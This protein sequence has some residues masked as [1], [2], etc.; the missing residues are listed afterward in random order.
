MVKIKVHDLLVWFT[1]VWLVSSLSACGNI[2]PTLLTPTESRP[3]QP[4]ANNSPFP[5]ENENGTEI[6]PPSVNVPIGIAPAIDGTLSP[7]EWDDAIVETFADGSHLLLLQAADFIYLGIR[8]HDPGLIAGNIFLSRG[9]E[10]AIMHSSAA[11]GTA[12]YQQ[13][14]DGW[15][16]VQDFTWRCRN[17]SDSESARVERAEFLQDE[18]WLAAN[19]LM[20]T[21]NELEYQIKIPDQDFHLAVVYIKSEYPYEKVPWPVI[22]NDDSIQPSSGGLP[23]LMQFSPLQWASLEMKK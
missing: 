2:T 9:V 12:I 19:G 6:Y 21:P 14:A 1:A 22:L 11:L 16:Q 20:G 3:P 17:T 18:G 15:Q 10:I 5:D 7:G 4:A 13:G 23:T 8:A